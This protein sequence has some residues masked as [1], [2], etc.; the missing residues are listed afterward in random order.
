MVNC[1]V[2]CRV[3]RGAHLVIEQIKVAAEKIC[4]VRADKNDLTQ[5]REKSGTCCLLL[6]L[7]KYRAAGA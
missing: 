5:D 1:P 2:K 6:L 3:I 4:E 7:P